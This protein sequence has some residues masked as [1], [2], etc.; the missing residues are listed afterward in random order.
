[1]SIRNISIQLH[2]LT[3]FNFE[4]CVWFHTI[5]SSNERYDSPTE[6]VELTFDKT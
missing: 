1:M 3:S 6:I 5:F 2:Q 4:S